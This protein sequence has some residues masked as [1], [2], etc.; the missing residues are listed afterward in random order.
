[1]GTDWEST[2]RRG[3]HTTTPAAAAPSQPPT[4][5]SSHAPAPSPARAAPAPSWPPGCAAL[6]AY[7]AAASACLTP[8]APTQRRLRPCARAAS[9][10]RRQTLPVLCGGQGGRVCRVGCGLCGTRTPAVSTA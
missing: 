4:H 8:R 10:P 5:T 3:S 2:S 9:W 7:L 1:M 6:P